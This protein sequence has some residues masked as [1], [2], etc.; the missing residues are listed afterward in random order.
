[1]DD[2]Q[3]QIEGYLPE[4]SYAPT[5]LWSLD[6][7]LGMPPD[8]GM[9]LRSFYE[10]YGR[11]SSGKSSLAQ[12]LAGRVRSDGRIVIMDT[13]AALEPAYLKASLS[14]A[15]F[16]GTA[17]IVDS[18]KQEGKERSVRP[19]EEMLDELANSLSLDDVSAVILDSV[20]MLMSRSEEVGEIGERH[21]GR[22][23]FDMA[24]WVRKCLAWLRNTE[25]PKIAIAVNHLYEQMQQRPGQY[26]PVHYTPGGLAKEYA[27]T[28]RLRVWRAETDFPE[29]CF[30]A[31]IACE[32][33][34]FGGQSKERRARVFFIPGLGVSPEMTAVFDCF[35]LGIVERGATVRIG[36]KS[37]GYLKKDLLRAAI[38]GDKER[39]APFF[40]L[41]AKRVGKTPTEEE[42]QE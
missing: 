11:P 37:F 23:A 15:G 19:Q 13:E 6:Q 16:C 33:L 38:S 40:G 29:G 12:Y 10:I 24:Q 8:V 35:A 1:M 34:R 14:Q 28:A 17:K 25:Q 20:A 3:I 42:E 2:Y 32:K 18:L 39:F 4:K 30:L 5:G 26:G 27:A 9:P 21:M 22:R 41:L 36:R 7:A 31:D